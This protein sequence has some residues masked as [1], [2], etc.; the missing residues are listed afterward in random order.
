[1]VGLVHAVADLARL[2]KL[3]PTIETLH[4]LAEAHLELLRGHPERALPVYERLLETEAGRMIPD[5]PLQRA[6]HAQ[7]L[8]LL[9][10]HE[11]ARTMCL[12]LLDE[13]AESGRDSDQI[14]LVS[15]IQLARAEAGLG[16]LARAA[17]LIDAQFELARRRGNPLSTG[18]VHR[19]RA[20][21]AALA[22]DSECFEHHLAAMSEQFALTENPW[23]IQQR[24]T[25]RATGVRRGMHP[26]AARASRPPDDL[27]GATELGPT[28]DAAPDNDQDP[29]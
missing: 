8:C 19:E 14:T 10:K 18:S 28:L 22:G 17:E 23:L 29:A 12:R 4:A 5:Y 1:V 26:G 2:A 24:D 16:N 20:K 25:L 6:Q 27:D 11:A 7:A 21:V 3:A 15:L 13:I 9:G